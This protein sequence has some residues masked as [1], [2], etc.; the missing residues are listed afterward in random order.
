MRMKIKRIS[1][2]S[3]LT[4]RIPVE[5]ARQTGKPWNPAERRKSNHALCPIKPV[6]PT[7]WKDEIRIFEREKVEGWESACSDGDAG[8]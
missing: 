3:R 5:C 4:Y 6:K 7:D 8:L 2:S 1:G